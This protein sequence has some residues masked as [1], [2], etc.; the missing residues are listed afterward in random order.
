MK[1]SRAERT[2]P[3]FRVVRWLPAKLARTRRS[4][5]DLHQVVKHGGRSPESWERP[6]DLQP[7]GR[8]AVYRDRE[9]AWIG[10]GCM[11]NP[12]FG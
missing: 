7:T 5:A 2:F 12:P 1:A 11:G 9:A 10:G 4:D 3:E 8:P 6:Q